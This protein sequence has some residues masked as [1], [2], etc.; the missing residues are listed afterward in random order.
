MVPIKVV[1]ASNAPGKCG[2]GSTGYAAMKLTNRK[3]QAFVDLTIGDCGLRERYSHGHAGNHVVVKQSRDDHSKTPWKLKFEFE[4]ET[5]GAGDT[6][7]PERPDLDISHKMGSR[8]FTDVR[9]ILRFPETIEEINPAEW[10]VSFE[11]EPCRKGQHQWSVGGKSYTT[12][13]CH[14][15][16]TVT[17][18]GPTEVT[19]Q[20]GIALG[21]ARRNLRDRL[22]LGIGDSLASGEGV[23]DEP[24]SE[25]RPAALWGNKQCHRSARSHQA[26]TARAIARRDPTSSVTFV[27]LACSGAAFT[28]GLFGAY[29]GIEPA[30]GALLAGQFAQFRQISGGRRPDVVLMAIGVNHAHFGAVLK[31]C[32]VGFQSARFN[33]RDSHV[34]F[35][36]ESGQFSQNSGGPLLTEYVRERLAGLPLLYAQVDHELDLLKVKPSRVYIV[37]YPDPTRER[38][39]RTFCDHFLQAGFGGAGSID[40]EDTRW[41]ANGYALPLNAAVLAAARRHHWNAVKAYADE[42]SEHGYCAGNQRWTVT[43]DDS[44]EM[45]GD[46]NGTVHPNYTGHREIA[47]FEEK[48]VLND[49]FP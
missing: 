6:D 25:R 40:P 13:N 11:A 10:R 47:K 12:P 16:T 28:D 38:N 48:A 42:F 36:E 35:N 32:T 33:C 39:G 15:K 9:G 18:L 34:A 29:K 24:I 20:R 1:S 3:G 26:L 45:Q 41:L 27:H 37:V 2:V 21:R 44:N 8:I 7:P 30:Q 43:W 49:L 14:L 19:V 23:P 31:Y 4:V 5:K 46:E 17:D 22:V